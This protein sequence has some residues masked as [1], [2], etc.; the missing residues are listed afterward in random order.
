MTYDVL[1]ADSARDYL[2]ALDAKSQRIVED[3]LRALAD[4][5]HPRP[6]SG[7]GDKERLTVRGEDLC[8]LH[9]GR[10]HTAFYVIS[11]AEAEVR[12]VD[13]MTIDDAHQQY[14]L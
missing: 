13:I 7:A 10:T 12:V 4:D 5:P 3:N 2:H 6:R 11:E 1:L 14:G 8:R 9:I